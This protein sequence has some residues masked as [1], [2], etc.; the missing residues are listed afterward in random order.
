[1]I[2]NT[3]SCLM[4]YQLIPRLLWWLAYLVD[5][6]QKT[7]CAIKS[8]L[9]LDASDFKSNTLMIKEEYFSCAYIW[10]RTLIKHF[11]PQPP[12]WNN[13][14]Y[15]APSVSKSRLKFR[16]LFWV[17]SWMKTLLIDM[18]RSIRFKPRLAIDCSRWIRMNEFI[19]RK[20]LVPFG[21][22]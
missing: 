3:S 14:K 10:L 19:I 11:I 20:G 6:Y 21:N 13:M 4:T 2:H 16:L 17:F 1:M 5:I 7:K 9:L 8:L 18:Y 12:F 22:I 15:W